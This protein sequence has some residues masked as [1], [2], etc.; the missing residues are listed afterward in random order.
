MALFAS[1]VRFSWSLR[2]SWLLVL[3]A[4]FLLTGFIVDH[5]PL[6]VKVLRLLF[7][8]SGPPLLLLLLKACKP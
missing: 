1:L 5:L 4:L 7:V 8:L 2:H 6:M 3:G